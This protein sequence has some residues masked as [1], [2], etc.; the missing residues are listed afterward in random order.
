MT[1]IERLRYRLTLAIERGDIAAQTMLVARIEV[2][3]KAL[4]R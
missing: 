3:R 4:A 1:Y 2:A